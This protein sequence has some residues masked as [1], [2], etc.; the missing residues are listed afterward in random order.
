MSLNQIQLNPRMLVDLYSNTLQQTSATSVPEYPEPGHLGN[1][2]KSILVLVSY[3]SLPFLPDTERSFLMSILAA[4]KLGL[5]DIA[6][7]NIHRTVPDALPD[8]LGIEAR[9]VLLFGIDPLSIGLPINF[10]QFQL[11]QF[12]KRTYLYSPSLSELEKDKA[13]KLKLW[14]SLK[15]LFGI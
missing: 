14:N 15:S 8:G 9:T 3:P 11:Q 12:N 2:Q 6:I 1:N 4:C 13:L 7:L 10:P 5:D